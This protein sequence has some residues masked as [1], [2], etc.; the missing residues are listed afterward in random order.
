MK[1]SKFFLFL[2]RYPF[3]RNQ[4]EIILGLCL[5]LEVMTFFLERSAFAEKQYILSVVVTLVFVLGTVFYWYLFRKYLECREQLSWASEEYE[6][7]LKC[8]VAVMAVLT[9][10][11]A[12]D[13][14]RY[15]MG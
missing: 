1:P 3:I 13:C 11:N 7:R 2:D 14:A 5:F 4:V 9:I 12:V 10:F 6:R 15:L 8:A